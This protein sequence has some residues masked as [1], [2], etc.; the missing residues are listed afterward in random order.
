M[1]KDLYPYEITEQDGVY[2][3]TEYD[4]NGN[5][6]FETC[7]DK[8]LNLMSMDIIDKEGIEQENFKAIR[9]YHRLIKKHGKY[10]E[11]YIDKNNII[12]KIAIKKKEEFVY[13]I[14][15]VVPTVNKFVF[16]N[17]F[18]DVKNNYEYIIQ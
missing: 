4:D 16:P 13:K 7:W 11:N 15:E 9:V 10:M 2:T 8:V 17:S 1:C 18:R 14:T 5:L 12:V 3:C 6:I